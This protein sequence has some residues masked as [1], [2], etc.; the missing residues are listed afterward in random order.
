L[1]LLDCSFTRALAGQNALK[2]VKRNKLVTVQSNIKTRL[3]LP[4]LPP[5]LKFI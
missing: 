1:L 3:Y 2:I 5:R 4:R